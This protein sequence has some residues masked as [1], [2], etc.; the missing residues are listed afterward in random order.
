MAANNCVLAP[1]ADK[2]V[3]SFPPGTN[4]REVTYEVFSLQNGTLTPMVTSNTSVQVQGTKIA[5][6]ES[7]PTNPDSGICGWSTTS[8]MDTF[9]CQELGGTYTDVY[10]VGTTGTNMV[11]Q[12]FFADRG[13][14]Q[15]SG[16]QINSIHRDFQ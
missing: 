9:T 15:Y 13:Q 1:S 6:L 2:T 4:Q 7:N 5:V 16:R 3:G 8:V 11:L 12:Q 14:V 10:S